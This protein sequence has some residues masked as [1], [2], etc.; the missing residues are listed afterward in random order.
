MD[1]QQMAANMLSLHTPPE[2]NPK[3]T[4][5]LFKILVIGDPGTGKSSIIRQF[6]HN[7]YMQYYKATVGVDFATKIVAN[8][9]GSILRLQLW[10][11]SGQDRFSNLTRVYFKDAHG[12]IVVCDCERKDT[13]E[14]A[15]RWKA[16]LDA[17]LR[18]A[19]GGTIPTLFVH[20]KCDLNP[21]LNE[22]KINEKAQSEGFHGGK[23]CS[24][25]ENIGVKDVFNVLSSLIVRTDN[26][27][28]YEIPIY[29]RDGNT[30]RLAELNNVSGQNDNSK[31][32]KPKSA[33][34]I[35]CC[36]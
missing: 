35:L 24:A 9:D 5:R 12:A 27:G 32:K 30:H 4:E 33:F 10:D 11:V 26:A 17:K 20:N 7:T 15:L 18:L 13:T 31:E 1:Q 21:D 23:I 25:K 16:D 29:L 14:G 2:S 34:K 22:E 19:D 3:N 36:Q 8:D 28:L 6:V